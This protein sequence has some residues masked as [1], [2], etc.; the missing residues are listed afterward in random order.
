MLYHHNLCRYGTQELDFMWERHSQESYHCKFK[1]SSSSS[2]DRVG[3]LSQGQLLIPLLAES[4]AVI[5][6]FY[7]ILII[8]L[9]MRKPRHK[10]FT[11]LPKDHISPPV[12]SV[13]QH[14]SEE[15]QWWST[16]QLTFMLNW[17]L[18]NWSFRVWWNLGKRIQDSLH[19]QKWPRRPSGRATS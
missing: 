3:H 12:S 8:F 13:I 10:K 1:S 17:F 7:L 15:W 16:L 19:Q 5:Q 11:D 6:L 4:W 2:S 9:S 18:L 14:N